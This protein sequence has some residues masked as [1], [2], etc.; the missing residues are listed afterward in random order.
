[1]G[2]ALM[3]RMAGERYQISSAGTQP[4][5]L[6][7]LAVEAMREIGL[8]LRD[9]RSKSVDEFRESGVDVLITVCDRV[10]EGLPRYLLPAKRTHWSL[11]DP[12]DVEGPEEVRLEAFRSARDAIKHKLVGYLERDSMVPRAPSFLMD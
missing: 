1:M 8:D 5:P 3:R 11:P 6:H 4:S 2:E 7:P 9:H 10:T 12:A